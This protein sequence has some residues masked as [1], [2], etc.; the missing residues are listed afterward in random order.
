MGK[1]TGTVPVSNIT[2]QIK[3]TKK[4]PTVWLSKNSN[5]D[6]QSQTMDIFLI[7]IAGGWWWGG[8][9]R[10]EERIQMKLCLLN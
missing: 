4:D 1:Y 2:M 3:V 5:L 9:E 6:G 7:K 8:L 10:E